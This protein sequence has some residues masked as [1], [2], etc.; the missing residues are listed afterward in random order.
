MCP[1][2][3]A[4]RPDMGQA[5][6]PVARLKQRGRLATP[7]LDMSHDFSCLL[8]RPGFWQRESVGSERE[9]FWILSDMIGG[10]LEIVPFRVKQHGV[11]PGINACYRSR[12]D[13]PRQRKVSF[14]TLFTG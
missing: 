7:R 3:F 10:K 5:R 12:L 6:R 9:V 1:G 14:P 13:A 2:D 11:K 8:K 4:E